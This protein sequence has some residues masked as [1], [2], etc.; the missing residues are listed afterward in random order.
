MADNSLEERGAALEDEFF[1]KEDQKKLA[2]MKEK[3]SAEETLVELRKAS[4]MSD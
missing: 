4:G 3:L 2:K 1:H